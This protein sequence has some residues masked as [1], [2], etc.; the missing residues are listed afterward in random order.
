KE[1]RNGLM[2]Y[3]G[4]DETQ[5]GNYQLISSGDQ[6]GLD[7]YNG[8]LNAASTQI[9]AIWDNRWPAVTTAANAIRATGLVS[10]EE[11][12]DRAKQ[13]MGEACFIRGMLM[14]ELS[15]YWGEIPIIDMNRSDLGYGRQPLK[16][17]WEYII[18]DFTTAAYNL[19]ESYSSEYQRATK[20]AGLAMLGRSLMSAPE[21]TGYR[22]FSRADSCFNAIINMGR[23]QLLPDF[24]DL[25]K[26]DI[27]NTVESIF[28][29]QF[30]NT[31]PYCNYWEF[32]CG[33][34]ACD[35]WFGQ[36]CYFSGYDFLVPTPF[37]YKTVD[38][39]G[40]WEDGD[41][42][43]DESLRYDF[44]YTTRFLKDDDGNIVE[45]PND[46]TVT[47]D[48]SKTQWTGTTD[49]LDPHIKKYEDY[50][51]DY[52]S[53][54]NINNMWNS[55]KNLPYIRYADVLLLH[56]EC[57]NELGSTSEAVKVVN[58]EIRTRAWG[59]TLPDD[60]KWSS[61]MGQ[62]EFR[63]QIMDERMRELCFEGW[64]HID[65]IRTGMFYDL[66]KER[67]RWANESGTIQPYHI[68]YPIPDTE[69][70]TNDDMDESDQ[71]EGY[72]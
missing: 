4:T 44:S 51:T 64:R 66:V 35:S 18:S 36:G 10:G 34:R 29:L 38:E 27:T 33:S 58:D 20:G 6:A 47:P 15:M 16:D 43:K 56:A 65:L 52:N 57:L 42:R 28:E 11:D 31:W 40:L 68:H 59:G 48:L 7:K 19:P 71:N 72:N 50:R 24:A 26:Y 13:L 22:D 2:P 9:A 61:G 49:E 46:T 45:Y 5:Q 62:E 60:K 37:C 12:Q 69:I 8:Q 17:V 23:Y 41:L 21:E 14:Y 32:D 63:E 3:L 67:N 70:K 53:G 30:N 54:L 25:W 55:G 39:G 1:S